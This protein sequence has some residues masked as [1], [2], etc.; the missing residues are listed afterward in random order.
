[1]TAPFGPGVPVIDHGELVSTHPATGVE[2]G[3]FPVAGADDLIQRVSLAREAATW[4]AGLG[5]AGRRVRL[6]HWRALLARRIDELAALVHA[7]GG[8]P[9]ADAIVEIASAIEHVDWA[10]RN[11][12]RVLGRRRVRS[13]LIVAEFSGRLEYQPYGVIGVIGPWNYPVL[14]PMGSIAYALAA[15]NAVVLKPSEYT[16]AV[17]Q[18]LVDAFAEV[19]PEQPVL[20]AVHGL[21]DVGATLCRAGVNKVAFTGSTATARKVM[22]ACAESLTPVLLEAG[23]KDAM[24]VDA[25]ADLDAAADAAVWGALTNAGQTCIGI[26]RVYAVE[27]VYND[28]VARVVTKAEKLTVGSEPEAHLGPITMPGQLDVIRR[29]IDDALAR[30]GRAVLGGADAVQPPYVRPTILV[31]V[32]EDALAVREETFGPTLTISR[33]E[34]ADVAVTRANAV[35]Y[36]LGGSVFGKRRAVEIARRLRSGMVAVNSSLTFVGMSTLP[37]GGV[38]D[39]GFGRIHGDDGL[40]EFGRAKAITVRRGPSLLP[41]TTF[42]RTPAQVAKIAKA[43][44]F[45]YGR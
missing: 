31:D 10:A 7:E 23:G 40:R 6:L 34:N 45:M 25:D 2:V 9:V 43:V 35:P 39:S 18:W 22:A 26:E 5:F 12:K 42:D 11:A 4:W 36:G 44:K 29:H 13:R 28:F 24:I 15:G 30:G 21:G 20:Q 19:V 1:M 17:G 33:V 3:R 8:K 38:G 32:P 27:A 41:S 14:T 16:P 37:F